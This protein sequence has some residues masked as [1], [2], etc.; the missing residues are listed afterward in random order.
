[1]IN[2]NTYRLNLKSLTPD[3]LGAFYEIST[4]PLFIK[5]VSKREF[6]LQQIKE[7]L[8]KWKKEQEEGTAYY[9]GARVLGEEKLAGVV[10]LYP[11]ANQDKAEH[12]CS[13]YMGS[14]GKGYGTEALRGIFGH[15]RESGVSATI[16]L[17]V[18]S[19]NE[20]MMRVLSNIDARCVTATDRRGNLWEYH[21]VAREIKGEER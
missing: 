5:Y 16:K 2:F 11:S 4:H 19:E 1:M 10:L 17:Y 8:E 21:I 6:S 3:D 20:N 14:E 18:D 13:I 9:I 12:E 7:I 15:L